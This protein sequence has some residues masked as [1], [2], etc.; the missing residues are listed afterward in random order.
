MKEAETLCTPDKS[1]KVWTKYLMSDGQWTKEV[2]S[3]NNREQLG[4]VVE[5]SLVLH[6][7]GMAELCCFSFTDIKLTALPKE[8]KTFRNLGSQM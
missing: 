4:V 3:P 8:L 6:E 1:N 2:H 7:S 5:S